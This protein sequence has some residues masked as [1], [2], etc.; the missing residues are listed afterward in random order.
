MSGTEREQRAAE[1]LDALF[2]QAPVGLFVFDTDLRIVRYNT[3]SRGIKGVAVSSVVGHRLGEFAPGFDTDE[4]EALAA[5]VLKTGEPVRE[6]LVSG[7]SPS[8]PVERIVLSVS[9]FRLRAAD[10]T[11][12]G[13]ASAQDVTL[14]QA[15]TQR[16]AVLALA[17]RSIGTTLDARRTAVELADAAVPLFADAVS[18]DLLDEVLRGEPLKPGPVPADVPLRRTA[19][20]SVAGGAGLVEPDGL[21]TFAFPTPF[22]RS[23]TDAAPRL[24]RRVSSD[25]PWLPAEPD[26]AKRLAEVGVHSMIVT[27]LLAHDAVLGVVAHYRYERDEPFE[28]ADLQVARELAG[29]ASLTID[30]ALSYTREHTIAAALQ[31]HLLPKDPPPLTAVE[32]GHLNV[33]GTAGGGGHWYDVIPLSG[34]RVALTVGDVAGHGIEATAT[35][36]QLRTALRTLA[37]RDLPPDELL[38]CLDETARTLNAEQWEPGGGRGPGLRPLASCLYAVYDPA[39]R[40][41][42]LAGADHPAPV[43]VAPNGEPVPFVLPEGPP[44]GTG[45]GGYETL[46]VELP[47][48][49][50]LALHTVGLASAGRGAGGTGPAQI[51][52]RVMAHPDHSLRQLC[53]DAAYALTPARTAHDAGL[54]L[55]RTAELGEDC[56]AIWTLP[57][58]PRVVGTARRLA[59][60]QLGVWGLAE[61]AFSTE[62]IVSELVTNAFRYGSA[63]IRLRMVL[64]RTLIC[65]VSDTSSTAPH[66]RRSRPTDEGGRGLFLVGQLG[67]RWGTRF[68]SRGKTIWSEQRLPDDAD[69]SA[70]GADRHRPAA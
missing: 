18:V 67:E 65:E 51:L 4:L 64:D 1:I 62:L 47:A 57:D 23:M 38:S 63:P 12:L 10:H 53:D 20:R 35:M 37:V 61:L 27:P 9:M 56:V 42:S 44:L 8:R 33:P 66:L 19:F 21:T 48:G 22:T 13:V 28:E 29:R 50:L 70:G 34:A 26:R 30:N 15:A 69:A 59:E 40:I 31:R 46:S 36:G 11:V 60:H 25:E 5:Q 6:H 14:G 49:S 39:T 52:E 68:E 45:A 43:I 3:A 2:S 17:H 32:T 58:D 55:A 7:L 54:L 16:L 24:L 41:C